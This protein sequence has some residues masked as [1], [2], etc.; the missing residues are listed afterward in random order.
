MSDIFELLGKMI[1]H[2]LVQDGPGFPYL[3]PVV[4]SYI[5]TGYLQA[6][7]LNVSAVDVCDPVLPSII[8]R[9]RL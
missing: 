2:C 5:S 6:A 1:A 9:V 3:A 8:E 4:Y 7:P